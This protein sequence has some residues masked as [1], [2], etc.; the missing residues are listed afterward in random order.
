MVILRTTT[1]LSVRMKSCNFRLL[2]WELQIKVI[3][4]AWVRTY[5][6]FQIIMGH[7]DSLSYFILSVTYAKYANF[8]PKPSEKYIDAHISGPKM[9]TTCLITLRNV[10]FSAPSSQ[11]ISSSVL[12]PSE[13]PFFVS[14]FRKSRQQ[15]GGGY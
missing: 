1:H 9:C 8:S 4:A 15:G 10:C 6:K 7:G 12:Q 14:F 11:K 2:T 5:N 13:I 3:F